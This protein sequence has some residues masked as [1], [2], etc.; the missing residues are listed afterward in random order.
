MRECG[1]LAGRGWEGGW[2]AH[3]LEA[4][5]PSRYAK[6]CRHQLSRDKK[7]PAK[8]GG[9]AP[10]LLAGP[11]AVPRHEAAPP[12]SPDTRFSTSCA[13]RGEVRERSLNVSNNSARKFTTRNDLYK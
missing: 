9:L 1:R 2:D 7:T 6:T 12:A 3:P 8:A 4:H 5:P 10:P 11:D 13:E